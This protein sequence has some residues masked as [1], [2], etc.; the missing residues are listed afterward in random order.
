MANIFDQAQQISPVNVLGSISNVFIYPLLRSREPS[1]TGTTSN[2]L[3][4]VKPE[5]KIDDESVFVSIETDEG[6]SLI[7][8]TSR[9]G[10]F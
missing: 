9:I 6:K 7:L 8:V 4:E 1:S 2:D 10:H 5:N 3:P